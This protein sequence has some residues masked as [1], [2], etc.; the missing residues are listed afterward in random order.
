MISHIPPGVD[1][2]CYSNGEDYVRGFRNAV[3][4]ARTGRVVVFIDS[5]NLLNLRHLHEKDRGWETA[6]PVDGVMSFHDVRRFG[7]S[8]KTLIVTYG[9]GSVLLLLFM[10]LQFYII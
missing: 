5:T 6:Y 7:D 3:A 1:V 2:V 9:N 4:Q 10:V 8:G